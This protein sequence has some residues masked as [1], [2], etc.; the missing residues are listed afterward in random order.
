MLQCFN[1]QKGG[2]S[3][4]RKKVQ[5]RKG[6]KSIRVGEGPSF[7]HGGKVG[8]AEKVFPELRLG[9]RYTGYVKCS[10]QPVLG[11]R[12]CKN[13]DPKGKQARFA[14]SFFFF[15]SLKGESSIR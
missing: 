6:I 9:R 11:R 13:K 2:E 4:G 14:D 5:Q 12:S 1:L 10:Y 15:L 7:R 8:L 3:H